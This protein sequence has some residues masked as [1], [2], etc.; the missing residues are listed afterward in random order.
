M[1]KTEILL[2]AKTSII[3]AFI[4]FTWSA[5]TWIVLP[6]RKNMLYTFRKEAAV[7]RVLKANAPR[8]G[9]YLLPNIH[10]S[11]AGK[12]AEQQAIIRERSIMNMRE[13]P[14]AFCAI[15]P[16]GIDPFS[17]MIFFFSFLFQLCGALILSLILL[18]LRNE[19]YGCLVMYATLMGF[20]ATIICHL[21]YWNWFGFALPY[22]L[23]AMTNII[24]GWFLAG[25]AI[26]KMVKNT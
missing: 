8:P 23:V 6:W 19:S 20:F 5:M 24:I 25:L 9:I 11:L 14:V 18:R 2:L 16:N 13:G 26:G 3:G 21:P 22:T 10:R 7:A 15:N 17:P 4:V 1:K 12:Q